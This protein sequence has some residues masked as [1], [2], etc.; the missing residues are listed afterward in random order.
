M[1]S[2][3]VSLARKTGPEKGLKEVQGGV[4]GTGAVL[5]GQR[6]P[7]REEV[8]SLE[9]AQL[10]AGQPAPGPVSTR[11]GEWR[12]Q[13]QVLGRRDTYEG[14]LQC[15]EGVQITLNGREKEKERDRH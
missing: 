2:E 8:A 7:S 1:L 15:G 10:A 3:G 4:R 5:G 11:G 9:L 12:P 6:A 13:S 14:S